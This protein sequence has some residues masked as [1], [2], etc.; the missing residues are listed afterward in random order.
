MSAPS[1]DAHPAVDNT[2]RYRV[3]NH[4]NDD[5]TWCPFSLVTT[6]HD[7]TTDELRCP[8]QCRDSAIDPTPPSE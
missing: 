2:T 8:Q 7:E 3:N 4:T 1:P 5:G 6:T